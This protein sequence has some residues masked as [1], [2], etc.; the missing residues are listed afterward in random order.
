MLMVVNLPVE[1]ELLRIT[2]LN[3]SIKVEPCPVEL[4]ILGLFY[5]GICS[6]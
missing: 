1:L 4:L 3:I 5:T 2:S 6:F